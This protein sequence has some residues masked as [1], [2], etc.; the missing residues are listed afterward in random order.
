M[1]ELEKFI[2]IFEADLPLFS[3]HAEARHWLKTKYGSRFILKGSGVINGENIYFYYVITEQ[4]HYTK[5][6]EELIQK[7]IVSGF[8]LPMSYF[9][10]GIMEEGGIHIIY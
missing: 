4:D 6:M 10:V 5:G 1:I 9:I 8:E 2:R 3:G 7:G